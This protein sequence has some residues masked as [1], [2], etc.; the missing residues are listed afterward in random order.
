M[1]LPRMPDA[2]SPPFIFSDAKIPCFE[3][4]LTASS[5]EEYGEEMSSDKHDRAGGICLLKIWPP[6]FRYVNK[7]GW[8]NYNSRPQTWLLVSTCP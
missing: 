7:F 8:V 4:F 2:Y 5:I 3:A 1:R 6:E